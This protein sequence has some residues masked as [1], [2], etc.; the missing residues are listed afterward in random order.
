MA[1]DL[2]APAKITEDPDTTKQVY[3]KLRE[4]MAGQKQRDPANIHASDL[5]YPRK[6]YWQRVCPK[7]PTDDEVS[8]W[9]TGLSHHYFMVYAQTGIDDTQE[10]SLYDADLDVWY[11]PDLNKANGEFKTSRTWRIPEGPREAADTFQWYFKQCLV[12]AVAKNVTEWK[13]YVLFLTPPPRSLDNRKVPVLKVYTL[14]YTKKQLAEARQTLK[15]EVAALKSALAAQS[16]DSL[17][18]CGAGVCFKDVGQGRGR[19]KRR[20]PLCKWWHEC[21]PEGRYEDQTAVS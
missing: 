9:L 10:E 21:K 6:A 1:K 11:S 3:D 2:F 16:P 17:P 7:P 12:Y 20:V 14:H 4:Y 18:L 15:Q 8:Y 5:V 19:P 13:L